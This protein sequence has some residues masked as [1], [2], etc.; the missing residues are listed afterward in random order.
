MSIETL[1]DVIEELLDRLGIYGACG[2]MCTDRNPCRC[3]SEVALKERIMAAVEVEH[4]LN[5]RQQAIV[6]PGTVNQQAQ[7]KITPQCKLYSRCPT[8][9]EC[10]SPDLKSRF[11]AA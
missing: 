5:A 4:L 3:C 6:L 11:E 1:D 9:S 8:A 10:V 2:D 7:H